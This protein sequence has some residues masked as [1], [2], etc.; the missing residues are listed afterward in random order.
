MKKALIGFGIAGFCI[1][2]ASFALSNYLYQQ[3]EV[4]SEA[5][6]SA[7]PS[8]EPAFAWT[9]RTSFEGDIPRTAISLV[10]AYPDGSEVTKEIDAIAGDCNEY[11]EADA[12]TY[13]RSAMIICYYAG[14]GHYYK[15]IETDGSYLVQR[16]VFE[17][18]SPEYAPPPE[19]FETVAAF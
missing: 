2:S 13:E 8:G 18:A 17:E 19:E 10:A 6:V 5:P 14:L 7:K 9:Y 4:P 1:V 15:V 12:D 11:E 3:E 16:K